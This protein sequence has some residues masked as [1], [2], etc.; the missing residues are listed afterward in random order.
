MLQ[1]NFGKSFP[2]NFVS[3]KFFEY[4]F[5]ISS[6]HPRPYRIRFGHVRLL[7]FLL[8]IFLPDGSINSPFL[9]PLDVV[10]SIFL[11]PGVPHVLCLA[12]LFMRPFLYLLPFLILFSVV[13]MV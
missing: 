4:L 2:W 3:L 12:L 10:T 13:M 6:H 9:D 5:Q 11:R 8:T 1:S 7:H